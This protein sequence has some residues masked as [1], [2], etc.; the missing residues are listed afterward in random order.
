M[1]GRGRNRG[2]TEN[3]A[4]LA[5]ALS[6]FGNGLPACLTGAVLLSLAGRGKVSQ[7]E[8]RVS[9]RILEKRPE[10]NDRRLCAAAIL[11]AWVLIIGEG[12]FP[13][14]CAGAPANAPFITSIFFAAD[15]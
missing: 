1:G 4:V 10:K 8:R 5:K 13:T 3:T 12:I 7:H 15:W 9:C 11:P 2:E 6:E 14:L